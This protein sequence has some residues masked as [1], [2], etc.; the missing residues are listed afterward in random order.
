MGQH[1]CSLWICV[2]SDNEA[3]PLLHVRLSCIKSAA[4][5]ELEYLGCLAPRGS[6]HIEDSVVRLDP[7]KQRR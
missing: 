1:E 6:A 5:H 4:S 2:I 7:Q 3:L